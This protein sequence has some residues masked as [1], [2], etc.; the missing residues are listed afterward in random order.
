MFYCYVLH[1]QTTGRRY[2]GFC[3]YL[4]E[5][6]GRYHTCD[7]K[8]TKHAVPCVLYKTLILATRSGAAQRERYY[9][10]GRGRDELDNVCRAVA[11]ATDRRLK[12][13]RPDYTG[14]IR[15]PGSEL[16]TSLTTRSRMFSELRLG[17]KTQ[18]FR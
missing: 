3:E 17:P 11:A 13:S 4:G 6:I 10:T 7:S 2:V 1:S 16:T 14:K 9:K 12:P 5:L 15:F 18:T 8:A